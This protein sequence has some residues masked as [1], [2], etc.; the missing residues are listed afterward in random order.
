MTRPVWDNNGNQLWPEARMMD[1]VFT[2]M[3]W[4]SPSDQYI[5]P[6]NWQTVVGKGWD[7][8]MGTM[9][10]NEEAPG[11][12]ITG[13][14]LRDGNTNI[15]YPGGN[16]FANRNQWTHVTVV[17][18]RSNLIVYYNGKQAFEMDN[19]GGELDEIET[20]FAVG[21]ML[22]NFAG[23]TQQINGFH[24]T[25]DEV[26]AYQRALTPAEIW[27][28][29]TAADPCVHPLHPDGSACT[30]NNLC[31]QTDACQAGV[32]V[33]SNPLVCTTPNSCHE[34]ATC[35]PASGCVSLNKPNGTACN[36]G[37]LC[38]Q[39]ET[40]QSGTCT[41]PTNVPVVRNLVPDDLAS[42][43]GTQVIA[44]GINASGTTVGIATISTGQAHAWR[45]NGPGTTGDMGAAL[46]L[47]SPSSMEAINDFN[48]MVGYQTQANGTHA[49]RYS[50]SGLEDFGLIGDGS[51]GPSNNGSVHGS[52]AYDINNARQFVGYYTNGGTTHGY[53]WTDGPGIE[54]VG[55]RGGPLTIMQGISET[56]AAVGYS[57][58]PSWAAHAVMYDNVFVGL[59]DLN[60]Y[61][62]PLSGWVLITAMKIS[63]D[64]VIGSGVHNEY[65]RYYRLNLSTHAID[66]IDLG[67]GSQW[68][69]DVNVEGDVVGSGY[70][71]GVQSAWV[72]TD[73]LGYKRLNDMVAL[74]P[75]LTW[76][77]REAEAINDAG[78][79]AG[80]GFS[81]ATTG[82]R[83]VRLQMP[84][85]RTAT[86]ESRGVC[87]G[88]DGD[89]I[90]LY[91]DGVVETSPGHFV[92]VFGFD[93]ASMASVRPSVNQVRFDGTLVPNPQPAPP[94]LLPSGTHSGAYLPTFDAGHT[95]TWTIN[96]E[97]VTASASSRKLPSVPMNGGGLGVVVA[98][99]TI[100][101]KPG[102]DPYAGVPTAEPNVQDPPQFG[103]EYHG[104]IPAQLGISP[105]GAATYTVPIAV[106]PGINGI[107]PN[108]S[109]TYNSQG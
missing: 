79:I 104:S 42:L 84:T 56:G 33:G 68:P 65:S 99:A 76:D 24:G 97:T 14:Y 32:C 19:F 98:G 73:Q 46:G 10:P 66:E 70:L 29:Y 91:S 93:N 7:Y 105:T 2:L 1:D 80:Y 27:S 63:G 90:C 18:D 86:C 58:D 71:N 72:Y 49:F 22:T 6:S 51:V 8:S 109:L 43:G 35:V 44:R 34:T 12:G 40:C 3:A 47:G 31:T 16:G 87:G 36:D 48:S 96:G 28:Y 39:S 102:T 26:V 94:T 83:A 25:I 37:N 74:N 67:W 101:L 55:S 82:Q 107:A 45:S 4:I 103:D 88:G 30:D 69:L 75:D 41:A 78:A 62:D 57:V 17:Y 52:V 81:S 61:V 23:P 64:F 54:D 106:P 9:C 5:C 85:A 53:R 11:P 89:A 50:S 95:L 15:G 108:L 60:D 21:C 92:A 100:V 77:L 59:V 20:T 38:T 13:T